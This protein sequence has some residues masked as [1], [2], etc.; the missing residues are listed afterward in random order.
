[1]VIKRSQFVSVCLLAVASSIALLEYASYSPVRL[2]TQWVDEEAFM[3]DGN[4]Q[5]NEVPEYD[6]EEGQEGPQGGQREGYEEKTNKLHGYAPIKEEQSEGHGVTEQG[7]PQD[8]PLANLEKQM[9]SLI[10]EDEEEAQSG[11]AGEQTVKAPPS[12]IT[13]EMKTPAKKAVKTNGRVTV[14]IGKGDTL[15]SVLTGLG[16]DK[17]EAHEACGTLISIFDLKNLKIGQEIT[18]KSSEGSLESVELND[19]FRY[20]VVAEKDEAGKFKARKIEVPVK[21]IIKTVSGSVSPQNPVDGLVKNGV[22]KK[23]ATEAMRAVSSVVNVC[24]TK[25]PINYE[26]LYN[27]VYNN[28]GHAVGAP[29]LIYASVLVRGQIFR[30]YK[31]QNGGVSEYV[32][33][34]GV[35]LSSIMKSRNMLS[36]PLSTMKVNSGFGY[37]VHPTR[38]LYHMHTGVDLKASSGTPVYASAN[39]VVSS[40]SYYAGYGKYIKVSHSGGI[41]TAYGHLSRIAVRAGQNIRQGQV[42]GYSGSTGRTTGAHLHYEVLKNGRFINPLS[43]VKQEPEKLSGPQLAKFNKLK[44][45]VNLQVVGLT[46]TS[47]GSLKK[48]SIKKFS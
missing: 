48:P 12:E 34:N 16:I 1:L 6:D 24:A 14:T 46:P 32:D 23:I 39:G 37:R 47:H 41:Q 22:K 15:A 43:F 9:R 19:G 4:E 10:G 45:Q 35:R 38:R 26:F 11:S 13:S 44:K 29:E 30:V 17:K 21:K 27:E 5:L 8:S 3:D 31:F 2:P 7:S 36:N 33:S 42:I 25:E 20:K 40:A 18:I 28:Q